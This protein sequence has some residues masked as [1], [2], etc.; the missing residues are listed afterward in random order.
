[1]TQVERHYDAGLYVP[2]YYGNRFTV[3]TKDERHKHVIPGYRLAGRD[4]PAQTILTQ[5]DADN[6]VCDTLGEAQAEC[7]RRNGQA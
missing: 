5:Q 3:A 6:F 7:D 2:S 1:M 4:W